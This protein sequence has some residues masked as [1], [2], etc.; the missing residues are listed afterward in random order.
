[1]AISISEKDMAKVMGRPQAAADV[2]DVAVCVQEY[3]KHA[4]MMAQL[5]DE[6]FRSTAAYRVFVGDP[7]VHLAL[8][9]P[10]YAA[11]CDFLPETLECF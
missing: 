3:E 8:R 9:L 1:M 6:Q 4:G 5:L 7:C 11:F 2:A 10:D